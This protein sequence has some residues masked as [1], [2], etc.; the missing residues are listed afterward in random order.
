[1]NTITAERT[2]GELVGSTPRHVSS[3]FILSRAFTIWLQKVPHTNM[4]NNIQEQ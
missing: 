3:T 4:T 1:M 2:V